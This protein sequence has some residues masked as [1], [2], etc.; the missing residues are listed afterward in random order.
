MAVGAGVA[1]WIGGARVEQ[2]EHAAAGSD[3]LFPCVKQVRDQRGPGGP[4]LVEQAGRVVPH[5][6][7]RSSMRRAGTSG[8]SSRIMSCSAGL[9]LVVFERAALRLARAHGHYR[10]VRYAMRVALKM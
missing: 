8:T 3:R 5:R 7:R 4:E 1:D 6:Q 9:A 2:P 10:E